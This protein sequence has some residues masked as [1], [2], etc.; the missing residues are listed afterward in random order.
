MERRGAR[1]QISF[2]F[3]RF[4]HKTTTTTTTIT[5]TTTTTTA[6]AKEDVTRILNKMKES[7]SG[8]T[9]M[10]FDAFILK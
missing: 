7:R 1:F 10:K 9:I 5:T 6:A 3:E 8:H 2:N 4:Q